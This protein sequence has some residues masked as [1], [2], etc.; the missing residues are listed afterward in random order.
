MTEKG[1]EK[2][3][4]VNYKPGKEV[5]FRLRLSPSSWP[6]PEAGRHAREA[7][8]EVLRSLRSLL[9]GAI[10]ALNEHEQDEEGPTRIEVQ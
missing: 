4:E 5:T 9:D 1:S 6:A 2:M 3:F 8:V 10:N 7:G